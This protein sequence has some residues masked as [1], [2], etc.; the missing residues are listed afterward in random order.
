MKELLEYKMSS[1]KQGGEGNESGE[2]KR[3]QSTKGLCNYCLGSGGLPQQ[4]HNQGGGK[5]RSAF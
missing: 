1:A 5:V 2:T 3:R 4:D